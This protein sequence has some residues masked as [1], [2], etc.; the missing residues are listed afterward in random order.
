M[1]ATYHGDGFGMRGVS[2]EHPTPLKHSTNY[3]CITQ[4]TLKINQYLYHVW[5]CLFSRLKLYIYTQGS[6]FFSHKI[7]GYLQVLS[8]LKRPFSRL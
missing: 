3:N 1:R 7:L 5:Q 2:D 6:Q 8:W 4:Y